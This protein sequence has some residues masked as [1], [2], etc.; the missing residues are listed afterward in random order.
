MRAAILAMAAFGLVLA[1]AP[2]PALAEQGA[3]ATAPSVRATAPARTAR[4]YPDLNAA[5]LSAD[6]DQ[7]VTDSR[8]AFDEGQ[9]TPRDAAIL[10]MN[11][12]LAEDF[13]A[14]RHVASVSSAR[15]AGA[16][17]LLAPYI[18]LAEGDL[19]AALPEM[20]D[21]LRRLPAP[22]PDFATALML[23]GSGRLQEA[24]RLYSVIEREIETTPLEGEPQSVEDIQR[25]LNASRNAM[26]LM[27]AG[28][29]NHRLG[30]TQ[31]ANRYYA[32][33]R[34]FA[35]QS[36]MLLAEQDRLSRGRPPAQAALT[37]KT[38]LGRW[39]FVLSDLAAQTEG[40]ARVMQSDTPL[41]TL[42]SPT[43]TLYAQFG[44]LFDPSAQEWTLAVAND[45]R[46][47][48]AFDGADR[49][50][51]RIDQSSLFIAD[52]ALTRAEIA[53]AQ[54]DDAQARRQAAIAVRNAGDRW[55]V[56]AGA[57]DILSKTQDDREAMRAINRALPLATTDEDRAKIL[58]YRAGMHRF[59]GRLDDSVIDGRAAIALD[60]ADE[61]RMFAIAMMM[62][63]PTAW[64]EGIREARTLLSEDPDSVAR[65]NALGYAL[66]QRPDG[67]EEGF[68]LLWRG[69][70][71][72]DRNEALVDSLGWA[73]YKY[74]KFEEARVLVERA[75]TLS[76]NNHNS[77]IL[78]HLGDIYWRL[79][80]PEDALRT[81]GE[82]LAA[83]PEA[84]RRASLTAKI[85][86][87][88]LEPAPVTRE[89]PAV[90]LPD[91]RTVQEE[92]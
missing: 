57:A 29:V 78:D 5:L 68:R 85:R 10:V 21:A 64:E 8:A 26:I 18:D 75:H 54:D 67:V 20:Q 55:A 19:A 43:A 58:V 36:A 77:E 62:D 30:A 37:W 24:A 81:W 28:L 12:I 45:L 46:D 16:P 90:Q 74:G 32:L 49:L 14:A 80:R 92:A 11:A 33:A 7:I 53:L 65:L 73:Y 76:G 15:G 66:I 34:E 86:D 42:A 25:L 51:A 56:L 59:A 22:M 6:L 17:N 50:L 72:N 88:L 44:M 31:E 40:F 60:Q 84:V 2:S 47:L 61:V 23:E 63:H 3:G 48:E 91:R 89:P 39:L 4:E 82:A 71:L 35:P 70:A 27:R 41:T 69:Y 38:A 9:Y 13:T 1:V 79:N 83:R 87:G 52:A